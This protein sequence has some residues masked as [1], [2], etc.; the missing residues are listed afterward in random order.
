VFSNDCCNVAQDLDEDYTPVSRSPRGRGRGRGAGRPST[1]TP[2]G[3]KEHVCKVFS[4]DCCNVAQDFD[5]DYTPVSRSPRGRGRGRGAG[6]PS[7]GTP[8]GR[9]EH[10]TV[11][12]SQLQSDDD[13]VTVNSVKL[14]K[15]SVSFI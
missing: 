6:R 11:E 2:A 10:V 15:R 12:D 9:K 8:A 5:E 7:T 4:N 1:G 3:R 13:V 14:G